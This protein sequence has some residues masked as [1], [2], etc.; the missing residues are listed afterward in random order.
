VLLCEDSTSES[1]HELLEKFEDDDLA[2]RRDGIGVG[3]L[4]LLRLSARAE[5]DDHPPDH[6]GR[7]PAQQ[8]VSL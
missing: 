6:V 1:L 8:G 5:F 2:R 4:V 3:R 7:W